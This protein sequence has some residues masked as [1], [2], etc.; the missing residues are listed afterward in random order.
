LQAEQI[1]R[2]G[3]N[4]DVTDSFGDSTDDFITHS[5]FNIDVYPRMRDQE[6]AESLRQK[7]ARALVFEKSQRCPRSPPVCSPNS[8]RKR[9]I[10]WNTLR[11]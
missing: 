2:P 8:S 5:L 7:F 1:D 9:S 11:A 10:C 6:G 4:T 3:H